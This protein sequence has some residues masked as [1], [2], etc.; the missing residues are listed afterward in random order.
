M[1]SLLNDPLPFVSECRLDSIIDRFV[2]LEHD[3]FKVRGWDGDIPPFTCKFDHSGHC[4][5]VADED[6]IVTIMSSYP[7]SRPSR[8]WEAH[9]NAIF[10]ICWSPDQVKILTASGDQFCV[11]WDVSSKQKVRT[12]KGHCGSVKTIDFSPF[13]PNVF[14]SGSRDGKIIMWDVRVAKASGLVLGIP[15]AHFLK[16]NV[17]ITPG[18]KKLKSDT[19]KTSVTCVLFQNEHTLVSSGSDDGNIKIWDMRRSYATINQLPTPMHSLPYA[20][21]SG[22]RGYSH[23]N[24]D[25]SNVMLYANCTDSI[26]YKFN[27][28]SLNATPL[29][30][31]SGHVNNSFFIK[32][33]LSPD[34]KYILS[35]SADNNAYIWKVSEPGLP[36][37]KVMHHSAEVTAV[38]WNHSDMGNFVTCGD[39]C[40]VSVWNLL[41]ESMNENDYAGRVER[42]NRTKTVLRAHP[43]G[44]NSS[45]PKSS[46]SRNI[47]NGRTTIYTPESG[48]CSQ[49]TAASSSTFIKQ[50]DAMLRSFSSI[51]EHNPKSTSNPPAHAFL[52]E[53]PSTPFRSEQYHAIYDSDAENK[54]DMSYRSIPR[55]KV[56]PGAVLSPSK[57]NNVKRPKCGKVRR[58]LG[59]GH[60]EGG[61]SDSPYT[62]TK[63]AKTYPSPTTNLPNFVIDGSSPTVRSTGTRQKLSRV[64]WLSRHGRQCKRRKIET[65]MSKPNVKASGTPVR[66]V[67]PAPSSKSKSIDCYFKKL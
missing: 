52:D 16:E 47:I 12:F 38:A 25:Q 6:G 56:T 22:K 13:D 66:K 37:W 45:T 60:S 40:R 35:G 50:S 21:N 54:D 7:S 32:S 24:F 55:S 8:R 42:I 49:L 15:S 33:S 18:R 27:M 61:E 1:K 57:S 26:I 31:Y 34:E 28:L 39:D 2:T 10:D 4:F 23:L 59:L 51:T 44:V 43:S 62:S 63:T 46:D 65:S 41:N 19:H 53:I 17:K 29:A 58:N 67:S 36:S 9:E 3:V 14:A 48:Y 5:A 30:E 11:L 20:G 64:D